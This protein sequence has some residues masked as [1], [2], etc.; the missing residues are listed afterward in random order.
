M[1]R[2]PVSIWILAGAGI[3]LIPIVEC[4]AQRS[5]DPSF[6]QNTVVLTKLSPP[7]CPRIALTAR[8]TGDVELKLGIRQ[9]GSVDSAVYSSGPPLLMRA[10][11]DSAQQSQFECQKCGEEVTPYRLLYTFRLDAVTVSCTAPEDCNKSYPTRSPEV[12][13]TENHIILINHE[14]PMCIC[15]GFPRV[16]SLKCLYL[17]RC[18]RP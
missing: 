8:I 7:V 6:Q 4:S 1:G 3:L 5:T 16:R 11:L 18:G 13:Q 17:W 9:D 2:F 12:T 10:A 14:A 15:G